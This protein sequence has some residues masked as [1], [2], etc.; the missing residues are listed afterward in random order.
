MW[1]LQEGFTVWGYAAWKSCWKPIIPRRWNCIGKCCPQSVGKLV[2]NTGFLKR[3]QSVTTKSLSIQKM[4]TTDT[5]KARTIGSLFWRTKITNS[6][7]KTT[8][9]KHQWTKPM[10]LLPSRM[11]SFSPISLCKKG[12]APP[13]WTTKQ[14]WEILEI[15]KSRDGQIL[16]G[17]KWGLVGA[18]VV[19]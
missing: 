19:F 7:I 15:I 18:I 2:E 16:C 8:M 14:D 4:E 17:V 5:S 3:K 10:S 6:R 11:K 12:Y 9:C 13:T 1:F